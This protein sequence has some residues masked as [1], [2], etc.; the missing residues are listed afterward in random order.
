MEWIWVTFAAGLAGFVDSIVGGGGLIM[1]PTLF[2]AF[3]S[4]HPATLFG[5][6][7]S[8]SVW[9][10]SFAAWR[11]AQRV[12]L[13]WG[14]L[15]PAMA[16]C[17]VAAWLGAWAV[18][19]VSPEGFRLALPGV[20]LA[21]LLYTL[22]KKDMGRDHVPR[23]NARRQVWAMSAIAGV[24]GL[25]DGFFGPG[26]GSFLVFAMVRWLGFDFLNASANAKWL[27]ATSNVA[28]IS[29]FAWTGHVW[30]HYAV[31]LGL[32]NVLGSWLGTRMAFKHGSG[33]VRWVFLGVVAVLIVKTGHDAWLRL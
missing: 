6:N 29:L 3:P 14:A 9:G 24:I 18:T 5:V 10:T 1:V 16:V 8:A 23:L 30:W 17:F 20:L 13:P 27:N 25:Y 28:A 4:A 21:V 33:F 11:Y 7:K 15:W 12:A 22:A 2:A 19:Q 32:A 26:T 31:A